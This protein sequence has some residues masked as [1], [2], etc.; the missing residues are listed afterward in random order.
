MKKE[1]NLL[2]CFFVILAV[3]VA[4]LFA[5]KGT[6]FFDCWFYVGL[7][8]IGVYMLI[9]AYLFRSDSSL[10]LACCNF[11]SFQFCIFP[12]KIRCLL[13]CFLFYTFFGIIFVFYLLHKFV[14]NAIIIVWRYCH[15]C[16]AKVEKV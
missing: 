4:V 8:F 2:Y 1:R 7:F 3:Y 5:L 12:Q 11:F 13:L 9:K 15:I 10:F 16:L 6:K 14:N